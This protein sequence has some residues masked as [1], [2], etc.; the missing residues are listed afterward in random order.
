MLYESFVDNILVVDAYRKKEK[1][2]I[3]NCK[4]SNAYFRK[5]IF[6]AYL[7]AIKMLKQNAQ[8]SKICTLPKCEPFYLPNKSSQTPQKNIHPGHSLQCKK[9][10]EHI[11]PVEPKTTHQISGWR[12]QPIRT[13]EKVRSAQERRRVNTKE[14]SKV[15]Y[16]NYSQI[17]KR[18]LEHYDPSKNQVRSGINKNSDSRNAFI[19]ASSY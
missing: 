17:I 14:T 18:V 10:N 8:N 11:L 3:S 19:L 2:K 1:K 6:Q 7:Q 4:F 15:R 16:D 9:L 13:R 12:P 5:F